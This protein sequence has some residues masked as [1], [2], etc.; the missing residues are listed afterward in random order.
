MTYGA[1]SSIVMRCV[2]T[3]HVY[4][5]AGLCSSFCVGTKVADA[6]NPSSTSIQVRYF[7]SST[8]SAGKYPYGGNYAPIELFSFHILV[9]WAFIF[10]SE[11]TAPIELQQ[12]LFDNLFGTC[13][14]PTAAEAQ[15]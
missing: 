15:L 1:V 3:H 11:T 9:Y 12:L 4:K 10:A 14:G 13:Q 6:S 2:P 8:L 7:P 5:L